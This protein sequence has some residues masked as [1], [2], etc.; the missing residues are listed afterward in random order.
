LSILIPILEMGA[1]H[2][3]PMRERRR[4]RPSRHSRLVAGSSGRSTGIAAAGAPLPH[5]V[6]PRSRAQVHGGVLE[7][8]VIGLVGA[9]AQLSANTGTPDR[10]AMCFRHSFGAADMTNLNVGNFPM[11]C[12]ALVDVCL[13]SSS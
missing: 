2:E 12:G 1:K 4:P 6:M 3:G 9:G 5:T 10:A 11:A 13:W 7:G 8:G